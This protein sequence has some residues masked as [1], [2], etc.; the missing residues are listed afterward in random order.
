MALFLSNEDVERILKPKEVVEVMRVAL[1]DYG[2]KRAL[3]SPRIRLPLSEGIFRSMM[4]T[5]PSLDVAGLKQGMWLSSE[6]EGRTKDV[7]RRT[8]LVSV[9]SISEG[10][11]L[12]IINSHRLNEL[13]TAA[14]SAIATEC[15]AKKGAASVGIIGTGPH[16]LAHLEVLG[17]VIKLEEF[18]VYSRSGENRAK[19]LEAARPITTA[20]GVEVQTPREAVSKADIVVEATYSRTPVLLGEWIKPGTHINSIGSSFA[21]KQ[22]IDDSLFKRVSCYVVDFKEQALLDNSGDILNPISKGIFSYTDI[23]ELGE[24]VAGVRSGRKRED[25]ITLYKSLGMGLFDVCAAY[26][27]YKKALETGVGAKLPA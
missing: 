15:L 19:F 23:I 7:E 18:W 26:A 17:D 16:A 3:N 22:V 8:E 11:L 1:K 10:R 24:V 6:K 4:S 9:Y 14:A 2:L 25:D 27:A 13:R 5:I 21:G 20:K 12:A